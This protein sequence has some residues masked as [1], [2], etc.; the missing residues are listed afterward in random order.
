MLFNKAYKQFNR[1]KDIVSLG[2]RAEAV[3]KDMSTDINL[4]FVLTWDHRNQEIDLV[5]KTV[6]RKKNFKTRS[7]E[8]TVERKR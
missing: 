4:P 3:L 2:A 8:F 5:A 7:P 6:M 1:G